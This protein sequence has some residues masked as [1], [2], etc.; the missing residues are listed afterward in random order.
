MSLRPICRRLIGLTAILLATYSAS[1]SKPPGIEA[2]VI[3]FVCVYEDYPRGGGT[4]ICT[5]RADGTGLRRLTP[6]D[7]AGRYVR[8]TAPVWSPDG[9]RIAFVS[10]RA[11]AGY[12]A[13]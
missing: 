1:P 7:A 9:R 10:N 3:A 11:T 5:I 8:D 6:A 12:S 4:G 2:P 13:G